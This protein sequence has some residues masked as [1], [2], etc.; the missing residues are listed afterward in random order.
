VPRETLGLDRRGDEQ[1]VRIE[2]RAAVEIVD[3]ADLE[4]AAREREQR[5]AVARERQRAVVEYQLRRSGHERQCGDIAVVATR[6]QQR[7]AP[8]T[9]R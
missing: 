1:P 5:V 3:R 7:E 6:G 2:A 4:R 9:H 8:R